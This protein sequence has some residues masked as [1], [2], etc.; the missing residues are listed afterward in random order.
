MIAVSVRHIYTEPRFHDLAQDQFYDISLIFEIKYCKK[1]AVFCIFRMPFI[2]GDHP[3]VKTS[4]KMLLY[5]SSSS[6]YDEVLKGC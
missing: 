5:S 3:C 4:V 6:P 2:L 1:G